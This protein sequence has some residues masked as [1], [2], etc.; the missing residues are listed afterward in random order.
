MYKSKLKETSAAWQHSSCKVRSKFENENW[1]FE[2]GNINGF[3]KEIN[4]LDPIIEICIILIC[5]V[6]LLNSSEISGLS[7]T[8]LLGILL[9]QQPCRERSTRDVNFPKPK[10]T[11]CILS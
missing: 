11:S 1:K 4:Y 8:M 7:P 9:I 2:N 6:V 10:G 5:M 3:S